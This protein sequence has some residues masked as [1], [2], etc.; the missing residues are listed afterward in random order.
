MGVTT[1]LLTGWAERL[2]AAGIGTWRP[3]GS[4][5]SAGETAIVIGDL[6]PTPDRVIGLRAYQV[7]HTGTTDQTWAVQVRTRGLPG[8]SLDVDDLADD[9]FTAM[10]FA[11]PGRMGSVL[12]SLVW[13]Q[14]GAAP[15]GQDANRRSGRADTYYQH[16]NVST[17]NL[18]E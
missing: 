6:P 2:A 12:V 15:L 13:R 4:P 1:D 16:I 9:V 14:I 3:D 5:Y 7:D 11:E 18:Q 8:N 17:P 10:H